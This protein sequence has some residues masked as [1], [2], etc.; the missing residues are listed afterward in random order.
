MNNICALS[1]LSVGQCAT[2]KKLDSKGAIRRR[3]LDIGLIEGTQVECVLKSPFGDPQ[4]Y[5]IRGSVIA[6][7]SE[8]ARAV[9]VSV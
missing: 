7:R 8:D 9:L 2:V 3:L 6:I 4:A 1:E 5:M